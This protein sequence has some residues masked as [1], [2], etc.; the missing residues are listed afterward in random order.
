MAILPAMW[1]CCSLKRLARKPRELAEMIVAAIPASINIHSINIAG[2][3]FI[4]F[5][6]ADIAF[7]T[8]IEEILRLKLAWP[9]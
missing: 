5:F 1:P 4:N 7:S 2:P 3:G 8:V 6:V 9:Y